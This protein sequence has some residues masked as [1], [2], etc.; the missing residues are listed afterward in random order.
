MLILSALESI[1]GVYDA[2]ES[3]SDGFEGGGVLV[4]GDL[5]RYPI[6]WLKNKLIVAHEI[7]SSDDRSTT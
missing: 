4:D 1:S 6:K 2:E 7:I 5:L 3:V